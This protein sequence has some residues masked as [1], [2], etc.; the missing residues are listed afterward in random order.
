MFEKASRLALR[1]KTVAGL[2]TTED[3]WEIPLTSTTGKA[4][5]D[6]I[7]IELYTKLRNDN[8]MSFVNKN[9]SSDNDVTQL[10]FDIVK[11]IIDVRMVD[12]ERRQTD[13][14]NKEKKQK[15]MAILEQKEMEGLMSTSTDDL[16]KM[17]S[18]L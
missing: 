17:I 11:H 18:E 5:L 2:L 4:N 10:Q 7:A 13:R 6:S 12:V 9:A 15:L 14:V 3:L 1:F 8:T 16:R